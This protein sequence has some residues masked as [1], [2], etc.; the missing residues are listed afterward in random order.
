MP[1]APGSLIACIGLTFHARSPPGERSPSS[2][3][4]PRCAWPQTGQDRVIGAPSGHIAIS[5]N[6]GEPGD[7]AKALRRGKGRQ[8]G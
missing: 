4:F 7:E 1:A 5:R 8:G 3:I 6:H 2:C